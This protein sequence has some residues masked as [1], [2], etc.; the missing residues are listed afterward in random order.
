MR[1]EAVGHLEHPGLAGMICRRIDDRILIYGGSFFPGNE[2][3]KSSKVQS[4]KIKVYDSNFKLLYD[5]EGK[6]SPDKG[7]IIQVEKVIYYI[8]G[9]EIYRITVG[10]DVKEE[11][12]GRF[13]FQ[14]ESGY[15]CYIEGYLFFGSQESYLFNI[16]T[17]QIT[18][19]ADFPV[20]ARAQGLSILYHDELYYLGGANN[21]AYLDGYKYCFEKDRWEKLDFE[22]PS[23][24]LGASSIQLNETDLLIVGGFN[25]IVYNKA[26]VDLAKP[27]Y[28]EKYFAERGE[29]FRWNQSLRVLNVS[30]GME[31]ILQNDKRFALCG[32]GFVKADQG[33]Y[34][35]SGECSPGRRIAE[36]LLVRE[37]T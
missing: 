33:Y 2:P 31:T 36:I 15:G 20:A 25:E 8:L 4:N 18:Q 10:E 7:I 32:A 35:V 26:V 30:T 13:D 9:S 14:I 37:E 12:L 19:K 17:G 34:I 29:F 28:R 6:N 16:E 5:Q 23:S 3:L 11:C 1:V 27:G 21:K 24:V 22:L